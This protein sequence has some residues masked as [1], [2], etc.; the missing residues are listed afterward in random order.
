MKDKFYI[1]FENHFRGTQEVILKRLQFYIQFTK[2]LNYK[3]KKPKAI[4][5]GCGRGE[6][7]ELIKNNG[8]TARDVI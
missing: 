5:L 3:E 1:D 2:Y 8:F 6:W 4:D 7:L